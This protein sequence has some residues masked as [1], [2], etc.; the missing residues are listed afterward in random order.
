MDRRKILVILLGLF[1]FTSLIIWAVEPPLIA[2]VNFKN[3]TGDKKYDHLEGAIARM[4]IT[5]LIASKEVKVIE[6]E[7]LMRVLEEMK[8]GM[9][10]VLDPGTAKEVGGI[11]GVDLIIMG[12]IN[13]AGDNLRIDAHIVKVK[14]G[15]IIQAAK[16]Y[17]THESQLIQMVDILA[18]NIIA[19][20]TGKPVEI[21]PLPPVPLARTLNLSTEV[22]NSYQDI[23]GD[24]KR[25]LQINLQAREIEPKESKRLPLNLSVVIDRSGS[26]A[27]ENKLEYVKQAACAAVDNLSSDD[28]LSIVIYDNE[29]ETILKPQKVI[30]KEAIKRKIRELTPGG[31]TNLCGGMLEGYKNVYQNFSPKRFNRVLLLSDGLAN[32]GETDPL[33]IRSKAQDYYKERVTISTFGVGLNYNE[34]LMLNLAEYGSGNYYFIDNPLKVVK[35]FEKEFKGLLSIVARD[36]DICLRLDKSVK[37]ETIYGYL[38][39]TEGNEHI[40]NISNFLEG[41]R[42]FIITSLALPERKKGEFTIGEVIVDYRDV[43]SGKKLRER[44][45]VSVTYTKDKDL[46]IQNVNPSVVKNVE[47]TKSAWA[48]ER[49]W[50]LMDEGKREE[51]SKV[52]REQQTRAIK[53]SLEYKDVKLQENAE[54]LDSIAVRLE[55]APRGGKAEKRLKKSIQMKSYEEY[56][57]KK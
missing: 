7:R 48:L 38:Y 15:E 43:V 34:N 33:V 54:M 5:D 31:S 16:V 29:I 22:D 46:I 19:G 55:E 9:S 25:Y 20:L 10:G 51:A 3:D 14:T 11:L 24:L 13:K 39:E 28:I 47:M 44:S 30:N 53:T 56:K 12:N 42:K 52:V 4:L 35:I 23:T 36:I 17:G 49:A 57:Q 50:K 6:R 21:K 27:S 32:V 26:M 2:V 40:I 8:L 1:L 45:K 41:D 18:S 37:L